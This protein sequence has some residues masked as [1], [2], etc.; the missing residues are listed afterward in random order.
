MQSE[1]VTEYMT[2]FKEHVARLND[3]SY[4]YQSESL[5]MQELDDI[6]DKLVEEEVDEIRRQCEIMFPELQSVT[7][8]DDD[9]E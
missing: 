8:S 3:S 5:A 4:T 6:W 9:P 1:N 2:K 7:F